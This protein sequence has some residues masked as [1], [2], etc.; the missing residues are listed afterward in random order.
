[1]ATTGDHYRRPLRMHDIADNS[2]DV[3]EELRSWVEGREEVDAVA[4]RIGLNGAQ[5][6][7]VD[8]T[9]EWER[10]VYP[11][12]DEAAEV[13]GA[14]EIPLH[15]GQYPEEVRVRMNRHRRSADSFRRAAYPEQG[16]VGPVIPYPENRPRRAA[17]GT[18]EPPSHRSPEGAGP[19][20]A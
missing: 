9:G 10:W 8:S 18:D 5:L 4:I 1:M 6:V 20:G 12:P 2:V 19:Q 3:N 17:G 7:L 15:A 16:R 13:A 11:S 14:L